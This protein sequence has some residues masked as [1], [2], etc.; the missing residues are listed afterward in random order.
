MNCAEL[1]TY[2]LIKDTL[3]KYNL[4]TG[5]DELWT[6]ALTPVNCLCVACSD[7]LCAGSLKL[8][9]GG[10]LGLNFSMCSATKLG[11]LQG[12]CLLQHG[13]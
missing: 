8:G 1:V 4:M 3:L 9:G 12:L 6:W 7:F 10:L 13:P 11:R 5:Q 2:D